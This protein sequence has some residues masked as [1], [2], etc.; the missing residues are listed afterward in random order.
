M[1]PLVALITWAAYQ[2][3]IE[4]RQQALDSTY[5]LAQ[6]A[7]GNVDLF[8]SDAKTMLSSMAGRPLIRAV[9]PARCDPLLKDFHTLHPQFAD[10]GVTN[11]A[12]QVICSA[13]PQPSGQTVS[14][15]QSAWFREV[16]QA[17]S[18][19][20][21][22]PFIGPIT[23]KWV[24]VLA[25]PI[26]DDR[27]E[28]SGVLALPI[29]LVRY[30]AP[31]SAVELPPGSVITIIDRTGM[32]V[33]R[34]L[35]PGNWVGRSARGTEIGDL[36]LAMG[37]GKVQARGSDGQERIYGFTRIATAG[38]YAY[39]GIPAAVA[40]APIDSRIQANLLFSLAILI[41][42]C[43][44]AIFLSR[45]LIKPIYA[46]AHATEAVERGNFDTRVPVTGALEIADVAKRF[47][48]MI[49]VR[50]QVEERLVESEGKYRML[51][52]QASDGIL[53]ADLEGRYVDANSKACEM[54]GYSR[55][56]LLNMTFN[57]LVA[58]GELESIP[59]QIDELQR[60]K[61]LLT[62]REMR[63]KDGTIL[64]VEL[65]AKMLDDGRLQGILRDVTERKRSEEALR[66]SEER[67]AKAFHASPTPMSISD[68]YTGLYLDVNQDFA[69]ML[70]YSIKEMLGRTSA[71]LGNWA[72]LED[73]DR[74]G[75]LLQEAGSFRDVEV[76][77]KTK[78]GTSRLAQCSSEIVEL[79]GQKCVLTSFIDITERSAFERQL[80]EY[81]MNQARLLD[82][83][84]HAQEAERRR[85]SMDIH[86]GPLQGLGVSLLTLDRS[87]R[88]RS[89]GEDELANEEVALLRSNLTD[90]VAELRAVL[91]DLSLELLRSYGLDVALR[92]HIERL[93]ASTGLS[94]KLDSDLG[95]RLPP[96]TELL[97]YRLAQETLANV[98]KHSHAHYVDVEL[99][100]ESG[101]LHMKICDDGRGFDVQQALGQRGEGIRLGLGSMLERV[102]GAGGEMT[103]QSAPGKG[104]TIEFSCPV[105]GE[106]RVEY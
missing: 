90:V 8:I 100:E 12:G 22:Q 80:E 28:V 48:E 74:L 53:I 104:T 20:V 65:S 96:E 78:Q 25:Y 81:S 57:D 18:F 49:S 46:L 59:R 92:R 52:E 58:P 99:R 37:N 101:M 35:D 85:L 41:V 61:T 105:P 54:L 45:R 70:G 40:F 10:I 64:T 39:A 51:M 50:K 23:K 98:R 82:Q 3:R 95:R 55:A 77:L 83:L 1:L 6:I 68:L 56:E 86:D 15:A 29:D 93:V 60:G 16:M 4:E 97:V 14:V 38:W 19:V 9:D 79:G 76:M 27:G 102:R 24:S 32:M 30:Q 63:R 69:S 106:E 91:A 73:R 88:R 89:R 34:T 71:E 2:E 66:R 87:I 103:I 44:L 84:M 33:A 31:L 36:V 13:M 21:G 67:F 62:E 94:V 26:L 17:K 11:P 42:V 7:A 72:N 5:R 43:G 75:R 47:N